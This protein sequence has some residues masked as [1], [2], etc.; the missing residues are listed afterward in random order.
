MTRALREGASDVHIE[1]RRDE[2]RVRFRI[3][4][5]L[6]ER[7]AFDASFRRSAVSRLK[8][9]ASLDIAERRLPQDGT[10]RVSVEEREVDIRLSTFPTEYGE[11]VVLRLLDQN[12]GA[13]SLNNLGMDPSVSDRV[14]RMVERPHGM[15]LVTGPTGSGK[16]STLY[17]MLREIDARARNIMTLEDPIEYRFADVIQ[18]QTNPRAGFTF[19]AGLRSMLRQDPDVIM[20]GE[21]RDAETADIATKAAL[22]GHLVLSSLHTASAIETFVRLFDMGLERYVVASA[23]N[24]LLAQRLVRRLCNACRSKGPVDSHTRPLVG[25]IESIYRAV[26]CQECHGTGYAGRVGLFEL[27][28]TDDELKDLVKSETLTRVELSQF[29]DQRGCHGLRVAGL[30]LVGSGVTTVEEVMRVT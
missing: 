2:V 18:G 23:L 16:T 9:M 8:V 26:G 5:L 29:L 6:V 19:A 25:E 10:F 13:L 4:G 20:V 30:D 15:V 12:K 27:L 7:P 28:E 11:K 24:G 1:P 21:M 22:T 3:D 14:R 17:A